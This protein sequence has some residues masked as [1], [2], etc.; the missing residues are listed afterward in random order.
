MSEFGVHALTAGGFCALLALGCILGGVI[1]ASWPMKPIHLADEPDRFWRY[2]TFW[3]ALAAV[4]A[5]IGLANFLG[6]I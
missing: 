2:I 1:P 5:C 3:S 6:I 4:G